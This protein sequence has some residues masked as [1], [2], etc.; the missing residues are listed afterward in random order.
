[1]IPVLNGAEFIAKAISSVLEQS[2]RDLELI[3]IDDGSTDATADIVRAFRDPRIRYVYQTNRGL[4]AARNSGIQQA[5]AP[6]IA[7]LDCDDYWLPT[8]LEA[9]FAAAAAMPDAGLVYCAGTYCNVSGDVLADLPATVEGNALEALLVDNCIAGSASSAMLSRETFDRIGLFNEKMTCCEDWEMWLR[10]AAVTSF[11][12]VEDR[13][14]RIVT[15]PGS[16]AKK[17]DVVRDVS[18][19][20]LNEAFAKHGA[21][22]GRLRRHALW[23]VHRSAAITHHEHRRFGMAIRELVKAARYR[24]TD[25]RLYWRMARAMVGR[26]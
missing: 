24:P 3:V 1:M 18:I 15:R 26:V 8:K 13:L 12:R 23:N 11:A 22:R 10:V 17:A 14:V 4:S 19:G 21:G 5:R 20:L 7:F 6:W 9:Q 16:L 25:L 2:M